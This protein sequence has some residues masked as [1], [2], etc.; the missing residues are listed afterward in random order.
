MRS[1]AQC[2]LDK[3]EASAVFWECRLNDPRPLSPWEKQ[4]LLRD[5][6][7]QENLR[8][9]WGDYV[10]AE[11]GK[12]PISSI[13]LPKPEHPKKSPFNRP[14]VWL[15]GPIGARFKGTTFW[16]LRAAFNEF[17]DDADVTLHVHSGGGCFDECLK[18]RE[19]I[20]DRA[21][22]TFCHIDGLAASS[23]SAIAQA[24]HR[25][26][27]A[28][29]GRVMIHEVSGEFKGTADEAEEAARELRESNLQLVD[30]YLP[31]WRLSTQN[32]LADL[33][34]ETYYTDEC[35]VSV[36][37][38]DEISDQ[39]AIGTTAEKRHTLGRVPTSLSVAANKED[40][41]QTNFRG[42]LLHRLDT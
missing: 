7:D 9:Q 2:L 35:A 14:A 31:R 26:S 21:G 28:R 10:V 13:A 23:A 36:G 8:I 32:L 29:N 18:M 3:L 4:D 6:E 42:L 41:I 20:K 25:I 15:W 40:W 5:S 12:R 16:Q 33:R 24:C 39:Q 38:A 27:I 17:P 37:L 34:A 1:D 19:V 11:G 22:K 30:C